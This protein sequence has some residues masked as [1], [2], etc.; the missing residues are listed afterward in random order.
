MHSLFIVNYT[1]PCHCTACQLVKYFEILCFRY[2]K[3][4]TFQLFFFLRLVA[5]RE[6]LHVVVEVS[7]KEPTYI[8]LSNSM[9]SIRHYMKR[10]CRPSNTVPLQRMATD[11][12]AAECIYFYSYSTKSRMSISTGI[13]LFKS[14]YL[15]STW[16]WESHNAFY[17][18]CWV[19]GSIL[20][21]KSWVWA[22]L[23][24]SNIYHPR[25]GQCVSGIGEEC[26]SVALV[27]FIRL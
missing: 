3:E 16:M 9:R 26:C 19:C 7:G 14:A 25:R 17:M 22:R 12:A 21:P 4:V 6:H 11:D 15:L 23:A 8:Q 20:H 13:I 1:N 5:Y 27:V 24:P 2:E 18:D 10:C